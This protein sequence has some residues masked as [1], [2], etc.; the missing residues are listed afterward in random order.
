M[1]QPSRQV[2]DGDTPESLPQGLRPTRVRWHILALLALISALTYLDRLNLSIAGRYIQDEFAFSNQTMGWILSAFVLGYA[3]FQV[4]GGW[5]G[6]RHGPRGVLTAAI[7]WWSVFT[8]ATGIAPRLP[9]AGWFSLAWSFAI[10]RFLIGVG[11][12]A[13][14]PNSNKIVAYWMGAKQ[15]GIGNSLFLLGIGLGGAL[16][17]KFIT[18]IMQRWGWRSS[19]YVCAVL[20][21]A[22]AVVWRVYA[23]SRPEEHPRVNAGE[24]ALVHASAPGE[25]RRPQVA[26]STRTPWR[27][28]LASVSAWSLILSYSCIAYPAYVFYTWFFIYLTRV[29]GL[30]VTQ[31]GTW[32]STP[33]LAIALLAPLGG[34]LSDRAVA[35]WGKRRGRQSAVWLG[36]ACSAALLWAGGHTAHNLLAILLLAGAAGFN[37]FATT[38]WWATCNDLTQNFSGSL[39]GL[40]NM[41]GN[42]GGWL[43]PIL[44]AYI[45][46]HF[47]WSRALDFAA[48][49]TLLAAALW[50]WVNAD[51]NLEADLP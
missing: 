35:H 46:T 7:L 28:I 51:E 16:T 40:M 10:V 22:V 34:W 47:G 11:E 17:P 41:S 39:S 6:D 37:L 27:R 14:F 29:R 8:A 2:R 38:T 36:A 1:N 31:G 4:P 24:L 18:G 50:V 13:A 9:L 15:R 30:T 21:T 45:A 33:F 26:S 42:L 44:T 3:L 19:F 49:I 43:S 20:G 32:G 23:T 25:A 5:L 12:A 48:G